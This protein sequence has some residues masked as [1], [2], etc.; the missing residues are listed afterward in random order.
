M[1]T[2]CLVRLFTTKLNRMITIKELQLDNET[3][4]KL[5]KLIKKEEPD[6][7]KALKGELNEALNIQNVSNSL[8]RPNTTQA[9]TPK[10]FENIKRKRITDERD[11]W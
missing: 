9:L 3:A 8:K 1:T 11:Y 10:G 5:L 7:W 2:V 6:M 4:L